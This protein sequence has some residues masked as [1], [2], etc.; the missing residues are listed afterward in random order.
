VAGGRPDEIIR[1]GGT[2]ENLRWIPPSFQDGFIFGDETRHNV[3][4]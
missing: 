2:M 3:P 1:P 4:G